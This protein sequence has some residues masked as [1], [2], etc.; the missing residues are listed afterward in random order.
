MEISKKVKLKCCSDCGSDDIEWELWA[1]ELDNVN[2]FTKAWHDHSQVWCPNCKALTSPISKEERKK[3][4]ETAEIEKLK[5]ENKM[6]KA[7][8]EILRTNLTMFWRFI[9]N[10]RRY[11]GW[12]KQKNDL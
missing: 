2:H 9:E 1:D 3:M 4:I 8:N 12:G 10:K 5:A 6:L 7:K 11:D